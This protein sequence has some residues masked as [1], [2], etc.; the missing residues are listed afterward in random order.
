MADTKLGIVS[1]CSLVGAQT[2]DVYTGKYCVVDK[3]H[4]SQSEAF[5]LCKS[6]NA[7]LPLPRN[8]DEMAAFLK[9]SPNK[10]WIGI[11]DPVRGQNQLILEQ[12]F[13]DI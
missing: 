7:R 13:Y 5:L 12:V 1:K 4:K 6:L 10:T 2:L 8:D 11:T 3:G 9:L